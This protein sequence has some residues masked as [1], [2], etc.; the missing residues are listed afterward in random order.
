MPA[1][2]RGNSL[3]R[4]TKSKREISR[5]DGIGRSVSALAQVYSRNVRSKQ[6]KTRKQWSINGAP[7]SYAVFKE[8]NLRPRIRLIISAGMHVPFDVND[9]RSLSS[10]SSVLLA[11]DK[12]IN[13]T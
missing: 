2:D 12:W 11:S 6:N 3:F 8:G 5:R 4:M 1:G 9:I 7:S 10:P 13:F